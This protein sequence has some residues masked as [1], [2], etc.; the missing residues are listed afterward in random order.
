MRKIFVWTTISLIIIFGILGWFVWQGFWWI[1][2]VFAFFMFIG[3]KDMIQTKHTLWRN[4]P[5]LGRLRWL[6]EDMRPKLYQYFVKPNLIDQKF[7]D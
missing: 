6:M 4:F 2:A 1:L 7:L 3:I 5:V